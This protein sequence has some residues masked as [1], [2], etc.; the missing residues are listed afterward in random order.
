LKGWAEGQSKKGDL[1]K[2]ID[3][4]TRGGSLIEAVLATHPFHT[5][6]FEPFISV[7]GAASPN[8]S[9]NGSDGGGDGGGGDGLK[10][11]IKF[12]GTPRHLRRLPEV[13]WFGDVTD[14]AVQSLWIEH[15]LDVRVPEGVCLCLCV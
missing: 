1:K 3:R 6:G 9:S 13:P 4:L 11:K 5:A 2:E 15:G 14:A 8:I 12:Y 10:S 7:Y